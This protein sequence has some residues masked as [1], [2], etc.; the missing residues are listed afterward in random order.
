MKNFVIIVHI[1]ILVIII[2]LGHEY[3]QLNRKMDRHHNLNSLLTERPLYLTRHQ[4]DYY[5]RRAMIFRASKEPLLPTFESYIVQRN[6]ILDNP[7]CITWDDINGL[8]SKHPYE[9]NAGTSNHAATTDILGNQSLGLQSA[10]ALENV[11]AQKHLT[12]QLIT[13]VDHIWMGFAHCYCVDALTSPTIHD[14]YN[15]LTDS[16]ELYIADGHSILKSRE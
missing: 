2:A 8:T 1:A 6:H 7:H 14:E 13:T 4:L 12:H 10:F 16:A 5:I 3:M 11:P 15:A 9:A